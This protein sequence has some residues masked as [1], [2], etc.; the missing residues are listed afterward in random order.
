MSKFEEPKFHNFPSMAFLYL[1][2]I[3][4]GLSLF[5]AAFLYRPKQKRETIPSIEKVKRILNEEVNFYEQLPS[6]RKPEF[7]KRVMK[8]LDDVRITGVGTTVEEQDQVLVASS[9][10]IPIFGFPDWDYPNLREVLL[11]PGAFDDK[12]RLEGNNRDILGQVGEGAHRNVMI[13][14]KD[15]LRSSFSNKTGKSNV[16]I[17]EFVHLVDSMDGSYDGLP[18]TLLQ[19]K[20]VMPWL[21]LMRDEMQKIQNNESDINP[22]GLTN[23]AEFYAVVSEYFFTRPDLLKEKH[24]ELFGYL[25]R[26]FGGS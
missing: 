19:K 10:I 14:S 5:I 22:Y 9:A 26:I 20:Y 3:L 24:P 7:E 13:L 21:Q 11:Y 12:F 1:F 6:E 18:E 16:G 17:H 23:E 25:E 15:A 8:F 2:F 4:I